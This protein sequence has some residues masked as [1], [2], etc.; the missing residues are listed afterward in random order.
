MATFKYVA[1]GPD[2]KRA[3]GVLKGSSVDGVTDSL[4]RQGY[5][6]TSVRAAGRNLLQLELTAAKAD[7]VELSNFS[8]QM[9]AFIKAGV[10]L[11]D[12][13]EIIRAETKDKKLGAVLVDVMDSLRFGESFAAAM[14][15]HTAALPPFYVSVLRSAE[16]TGE[17]DVVMAQLARYIE[18]DVE[19]RRSIRSALTYPVLVMGLAVGVVLVLVLFVLPRF[20]VFFESF[21]AELPLTTRLLLGFTDFV[22]AWYPVVLGVLVV[23]GAALIAGLRTERGR[24]LRDRFLLA[25][26]VVGDVVRFMAIERFCRILTSMIKAGVPIPEA[27]GLAASG[28][29]NL[30]YERSIGTAR[31]EM[32]EGGGISRPIART[33]LFPGAVT[34]MMRVGEETGTLDDQLENVSDF[35]EKELQHKLK[36]LTSLFEPTIVIMVGVVVGFVAVALISAIYGVYNQVDVP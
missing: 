15:A 31:K 24:V 32:L 6:V 7:L 20:K 29:N 26:P 10:P 19:G 17:L 9:A 16:A 22:T 34:Q 5:D 28:A 33:K 3:T 25:L 8:R 35:Y 23:L 36:R 2:G 4:T 18:R 27:L 11:L 13:L 21:H 14:A 12:A 30:V 1:V